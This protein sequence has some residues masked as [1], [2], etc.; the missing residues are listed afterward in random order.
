MRYRSRYYHRYV[1]FTPQ[2]FFPTETFSRK[3]N[4]VHLLPRVFLL[5]SVRDSK[6]TDLQLR[7]VKRS[8]KRECAELPGH[9]LTDCPRSVLAETP[10]FA[11]FR[12]RP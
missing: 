9:D 1:S 4:Q 5:I 2:I 11:S 3:S 6:M 10:N 7:V 12:E 8:M